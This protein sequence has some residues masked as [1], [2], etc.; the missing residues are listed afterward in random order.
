M[1]DEARAFVLRRKPISSYLSSPV[2]PSEPVE[3]NSFTSCFKWVCVDQSSLWLTGLSWSVFFLFAVAV[4]LASHFLLQCSSCDANLQRPYHI[5]VQISLSVFAAISFVCLSR[6]SRKYGIRKFLFLDKL[7]D[8]SDNVRR[9]YSQQLQRSVK[10]WTWFVLPCFA[11]ETAYKLWWFIDGSTNIPYYGNLYVSDTIL[12]ALELLS[13]LYRTAI[14]ILVCVLY[15]LICYLHILRL[16]DFAHVF[17]KETEV[18]S[19][20]KE[21]LRFRRTLRIISHRFRSFLLLCLIL[22][23]ASQFIFVLLLTRSGA[24]ANIFKAGE[25]SL[26]SVSL[27]TGLFICLRSATKVSHKAQSITGLA[28]K[29]HICATI[30]SFDDNDGETPR[31]EVAST[32]VF[33]ADAEWESEEEEGDGDDDLNNAKI[34]PIYAHT[35]SFHKRQALG[36]IF[37]PYSELNSLF[38]Y[39]C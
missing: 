38:S 2:L 36:L 1:E 19:I 4:P 31:I 23:T 9:G 32:H 8:S 5:P 13:W 18:V 20:L 39:G 22:V 33:P 26:C 34:M 25:L 7:C 11:V 15:R 35:I 10:L 16:E 24:N 3:L 28:A 12:C 17:E 21:H 30:N 14:F 6:W 37:T 27:L 29:W